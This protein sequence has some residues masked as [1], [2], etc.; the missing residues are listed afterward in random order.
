MA[1]FLAW[2]IIASE[3]GEITATKELDD[4]VAGLKD[5]EMDA[6]K[7]RGAELLKLIQKRTR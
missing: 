1:T 6:A 7:T 2:L 4:T 3:R 5:G